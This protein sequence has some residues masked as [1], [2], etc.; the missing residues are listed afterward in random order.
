MI[1]E[2]FATIAMYYSNDLPTTVSCPYCFNRFLL[3]YSD[4][5]MMFDL[6]IAQSKTFAHH[7]DFFDVIDYFMFALVT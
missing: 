1:F 4:A 7:Q 5:Y 3:E 2:L 6:T